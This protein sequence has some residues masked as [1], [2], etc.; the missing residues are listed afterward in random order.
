M[1]ID[2]NNPREIRGRD[3]ARRYTI[4]EENGLWLV[5]S[6]SGKSTRYKVSLKLQTC[7]CPDFQLRRYKCKHLFAVEHSFEQEF[8][9]QL[10]REEISQVPKPVRKRKTIQREWSP[11][12]KSQVHEKSLFQELLAQLCTGI[13]EPIQTNGRPSLLLKNT[14]FACVFKVFSTFSGRRFMT[15]LREAYTKNFVSELPHYNAIFRYLQKESLTPYLKM[16]IE[17]SSLPLSALENNFAIDASGFA[18]TGSFTWLYAKYTE[19]RLIE[20]QDWLKMHIC[21]GTETNIITA[22][23]ITER[24][25]HDT[26][27]FVPLLEETAENFEIMEISADAAYLSKAN[28]QAAVNIGSYPFIS[29]K[30][31]S[32][33]TD[34][35]GNELW[36]KLFHYYAMN[37]EKFLERY[38]KR[39]NVESTFHAIKALFGGT[40]RSKMRTAQINECLARILCHNLVCLVRSIFNFGLQPEF[41]KEI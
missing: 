11:Y 5:P 24:Y 18:T 25:E 2:S 34:K 8:L 37:R 36:N 7:N 22:A 20:K 15:D 12:S 3:I 10:T 40:L 32:R 28:L 33:E 30:S 6:S 26:N 39:S 9:G 1:N 19:P 29:W 4:K 13:D 41:W 21:V 35:L 17:Q 23:R 14:I 31:N 38:H 27:Y 16:M